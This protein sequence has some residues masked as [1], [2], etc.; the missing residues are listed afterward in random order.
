MTVTTLDIAPVLAAAEAKNG[1]I[2]GIRTWDVRPAKIEPTY[3]P[4]A[5]VTLAPGIFGY[6]A[7]GLLKQ[8]AH[9]RMLYYVAPVAQADIDTNYSRAVAFF[10]ETRRVWG[11]TTNI[12]TANDT[13]GGTVNAWGRVDETEYITHEGIQ[14]LTYAGVDYWGFVLTVPFKEKFIAT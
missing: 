5:L 11:D 1:T 14:I 7:W 8:V 3:L 2:P 10:D 12:G 6:A 13:L 4:L 9:L